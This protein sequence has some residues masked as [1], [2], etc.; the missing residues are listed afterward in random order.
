MGKDISTTLPVK[1]GDFNIIESDEQS[2]EHVLMLSPG[3]LKSNALLG[4]GI[5]GYIN[6][7][8]SPKTVQQLEKS[9]RLNL[10]QD[11]ATR[12][13]VNIDPETTNISTGAKYE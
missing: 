6:A 2:V 9:I 11:G 3:E 1:D 8:L 10:T 5:R 13:Q 4:V 12:I 7:T